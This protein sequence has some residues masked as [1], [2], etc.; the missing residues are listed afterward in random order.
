MAK[1]D[2]D[3]PVLVTG[4]LMVTSPLPVPPGRLVSSVTEPPLFSAASSV[5]VLRSEGLPIE[6]GVKTG[7]PEM[8]R[9]VVFMTTMSSGS[10]HQCPPWPCGADR[11]GAR[12][13]SR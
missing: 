2:V 1:N 10:S 11:S 12:V 8:L 9:S 7:P 3:P 4:A 6:V 5:D 13:A